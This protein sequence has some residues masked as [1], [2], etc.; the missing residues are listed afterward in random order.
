MQKVCSIKVLIREEL[1]GVVVQRSQ[2]RGR[3]D[4]GSDGTRQASEEM[5][6][7]KAQEKGEDKAKVRWDQVH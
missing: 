4:G 3:G 1:K 7:G 2:L 5:Q 6:R